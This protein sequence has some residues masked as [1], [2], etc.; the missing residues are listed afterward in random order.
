MATM[1][2]M[3]MDMKRR[4]TYRYEMLYEDPYIYHL[5]ISKMIKMSKSLKNMGISEEI[6]SILIHIVF[7]NAHKKENQVRDR[8]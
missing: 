7:I 5:N 8:T 2:I 4:T 3:I 6:Y 1:G